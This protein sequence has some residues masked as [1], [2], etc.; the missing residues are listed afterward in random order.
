MIIREE[1]NDKSIRKQY[2][3]EDAAYKYQR[4]LKNRCN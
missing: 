4:Y 1:S 3:N 2:S